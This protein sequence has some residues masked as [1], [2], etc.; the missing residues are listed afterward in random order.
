LLD[1][2]GIEVGGSQPWDVHVHDDR[3]WDRVIR[4]RELGLGEAYMDG[5]WD[6]PEVDRFL[7][8]IL[9]ADVR[10]E[11]KVG[12]G[13][14]KLY[15][16]SHLTNRQDRKRA[17]VNAS[18]HYDIGND[19]YERMLDKRMIYSCGYWRNA[20]DLDAAQ[21]AKL[22]LICTKLQLEP[23]M[24]LLDIGCGWGGLSAFAAE[25]YQVEVTGISPAI[26][27]VR[28][29]RARTEGLSVS[30][31]QADYRDMTG[32]FD[33]IVSVGMFEHVGA[34]NYRTFFRTCDRLLADDGLM[35]HHTI[36]S[37]SS[38]K[39]FDPWFDRYIFPGG[40][41]PSVAQMAKAAE[42]MFTF[43]D[44]HSFGPDYDTT[45]Q[46]WYSN[47]EAAWPDLPHYDERFRRMWRYY[48]KAS[49]AGFR[50]RN[51]QLWQMVFSRT[52]RTSDV[53]QAVR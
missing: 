10:S 43:E 13:M 32:T 40:M 31:R 37:N 7:V 6:S 44:L 8:R 12:P 51:T 36:G 1:R 5:W 28:L 25:R 49:M 22:D 9:L 52:M 46:H 3:L 35:L 29:A 53:Y 14:L 27:Q 20:V 41:L 30:I 21:E 16:M 2:A 42:P 47:I 24:T 38:K 15:A 19:L 11:L 48:L 23:G 34:K 50:V 33:R 26:E 4:D 39:V 17:A 18:A 45:L